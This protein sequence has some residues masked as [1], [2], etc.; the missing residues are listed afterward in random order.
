MKLKS[1]DPNHFLEQKI[2]SVSFKLIF[3]C[4]F[5][6]LTKITFFEKKKMKFWNLLKMF[7]FSVILLVFEGP[8]EDCNLGVINLIF[9]FQEP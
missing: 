3:L 6:F 7:D 8:Q 5:E 4:S 9:G 1:I 2:N